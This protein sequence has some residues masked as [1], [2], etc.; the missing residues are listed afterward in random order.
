MAIARKVVTTMQL[1]KPK[2]TIQQYHRIA[3][4]IQLVQK[5]TAPPKD[6]DPSIS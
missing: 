5:F 2:F 6:I 3:E 4:D 1:L